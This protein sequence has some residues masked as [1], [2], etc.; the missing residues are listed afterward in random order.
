MTAL[1]GAIHRDVGAC[2]RLEEHLAGL[3]EA[4][5]EN[6]A[7]R[8]EEL[9][10]VDEAERHVVRELVDDLDRTSVPTLAAATTASAWGGLPP[11]PARSPA[12]RASPGPE[13]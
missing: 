4:A 13:A 7:A 6:D 9:H 8:I 11:W 5:A 2:D 3:H 1:G 10:R 12:R